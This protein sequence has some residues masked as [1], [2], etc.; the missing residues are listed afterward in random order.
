VNHEASGLSQVA[1][2][3]D[4]A[5]RRLHGVAR[6]TELRANQRLSESTGA[7]VYLKREDLQPVRSYKLRGAY[8][9]IAQLSPEAQAHGVVCAS[10]GNHAQGVAWSCARLGIKGQIFVPTTTPRQKRDRI[11]ALGAGVVELVVQGETYDAA[12]EAA[13]TSA[14]TTGR[15]LV[16]AF[17]ALETIAGQGTIGPEIVEQ[18][19]AAPDVVLLPVGGGGL[20]SGIGAWFAVH[21]PQTLIHGIEPAGAASMAAAVAAG[22]PVTLGHVE[23]FVDGAAVRR[24]GDL[25]TDIVRAF[26]PQLSA[27]PEGQVCSEML[28]LY[29]TDGI[30]AEPAGA[31]APSVLRTGHNDTTLTVQ[32]D[33]TVVVVI[34]G[35]NND[36]SRYSEVI[37]RSLV[38]EGR[39]HYFLV[40]FPQEPGALR[41]F[42]DGVLGPDDDIVLFEYM[43]KSNREMGPALVGLELGDAADY[44]SLLARIQASPLN[45]EPIS[46]ASDFYRYLL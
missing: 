33:Q 41:R 1:D 3:V 18:L 20:I 9:F 23:T 16:P 17:D 6:R 7:R 10:A 31:L 13:A 38:H 15:A 42:L 26:K 28:D 36:I 34:S 43:K 5:A 19:G 11:M 40:S 44:P 21:F 45:V 37:E 27:V 2:L 4:Q 32:P 24:A 14:N 22:E 30:I 35:G 8:N 25:T 46:P 12:A 39:K 29:Q